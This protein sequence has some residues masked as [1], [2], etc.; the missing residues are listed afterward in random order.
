MTLDRNISRYAVQPAREAT[1]SLEFVETLVHPHEHELRNILGFIVV[2]DESSRPRSNA[3]AQTTRECIERSVVTSSH[4]S[5]E[6]GELVIVTRTGDCDLHRRHEAETTR[7][8]QRV[9]GPPPFRRSRTEMYSHRWAVDTTLTA[10][11]Y[12]FEWELVEMDR[13]G[14]IV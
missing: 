6:C 5:N 9:Y 2:A 12:P 7:R 3:I 13:R 11:W 10:G 8:G 14:I 4:F 1:S